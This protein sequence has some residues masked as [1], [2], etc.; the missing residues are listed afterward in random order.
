MYT[1]KP[2]K[3]SIILI[4]FFILFIAVV[5]TQLVIFFDFFLK[6][7]AVYILIGLWVIVGAYLLVLFPLY[8]KKTRFL[9][10]D[11][12]I[13]KYTFLFAFK[14]QY[15]TMDSVKSVSTIITPFSRITGMNFI[16]INALG[17]KMLLPL[18]V[19]KDC[20]E[21]T[22]LINENVS[23]RHRMKADSSKE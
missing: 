19:K 12:D 20:K 14:Y 22:K 16:V 23:H 9:V 7:V 11:G 10:S 8:F 6:I 15:M 3:R 13:V 18:L 2:A 1:C 4:Y 17:A 5:I 21:I